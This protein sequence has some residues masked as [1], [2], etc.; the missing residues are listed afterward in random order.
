M[1]RSLNGTTALILERAVENA[2]LDCSTGPLTQSPASYGVGHLDWL[3]GMTC[4]VRADGLVLDNV[5]PSGG[6]ATLTRDGQPYLATTYEVG[7]NFNPTVTPMPLQTVRYPA[8]TNLT[9]KK[10]IVSASIK[11]FNSLGILYNGQYLPTANID[12]F[13]FDSAPQPYSGVIQLEDSSNWDLDKEKLV[14][15]SQQDPLPF[16]LM[17]LDIELAGA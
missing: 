8:G 12:T 3:N 7:L 13:N 14:T 16:Y 6:L 17:F 11:V 9:H 10:R 2:F 4:R 5:V 15:F 1:Q